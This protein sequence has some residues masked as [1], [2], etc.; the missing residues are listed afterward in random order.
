MSRILF[1]MALGAILALL[2]SRDAS[3]GLLLVE[4]TAPCGCGTQHST[5]AV[6]MAEESGA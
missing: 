4:S 1:G 6:T 3:R 2:A 5:R